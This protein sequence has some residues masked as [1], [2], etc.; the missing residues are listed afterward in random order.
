MTGPCDRNV[1]YV[2]KDEYYSLAQ[3]TS[4]KVSGQLINPFSHSIAAGMI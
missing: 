2:E 3:P 1:F 4:F